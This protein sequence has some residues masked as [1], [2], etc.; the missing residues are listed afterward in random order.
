MHNPS[1]IHC[2]GHSLG[3]A[4]AA[5]N[6]DLLTAGKVAD[7]VLYTFGS[8]RTGDSL[9]AKSLTRR[10]GAGQIYRVSHPADPVPMIPLFP[11]WH[12]P[13]G[14]SGLG[15]A[16]T[17]NALI[18]VGA[19]SM[20]PSYIPGVRDHSWA[21]LGYGGARADDDL[22]IK[23]WL[24]RAVD[25]RGSFTMGSAR[26]L[27]MI[28]RALRWLLAMAGKMVMGGIGLTVTMGATVLDQLAWLLGHAAQLSKEIGFGL[29]GLIGAIFGFL[30]RKIVGAMDV[31]TAFLRWVLELLYSSLQAVAQ[32]ALSLVS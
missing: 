11:Y 10:I 16:A 12:L 13:Y 21:T 9:F 3:G 1:R 23:G 28:G 18:N 19:H 8:P 4:L 20:E 26:L 14:L 2:V 7:V 25:G 27:S 5:L 31:T 24:E 30:G 22:K 6:A 15:I 32:R 29:V 17:S